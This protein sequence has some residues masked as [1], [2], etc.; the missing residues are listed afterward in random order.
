MKSQVESDK[1]ATAAPA[2][3]DPEPLRCGKLGISSLLGVDFA[4]AGLAF[5][6][7]QGIWIPVTR[8]KKYARQVAQALLEADLRGSISSIAIVG[9]AQIID[10]AF[11]L[12][13]QELNENV[14]Q[15]VKEIG[16]V[17]I[18]LFACTRPEAL[19][20]RLVPEAAML[21]QQIGIEQLPGPT[22]PGQLNH[23]PDLRSDPRLQPT[24]QRKMIEASPH[25]RRLEVVHHDVLVPTANQYPNW[26]AFR[27]APLS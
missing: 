21:G 25:Q 12:F 5:N 26:G 13:S 22:P 20:G 24:R 1:T 18:L 4:D 9:A 6:H 27:G 7:G 10:E 17:R 8:A 16:L 2:P 23:A 19:D 3:P 15:V 14:A 11:S